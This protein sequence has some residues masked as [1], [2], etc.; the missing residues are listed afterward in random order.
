MKKQMKTVLI[1]AACLLLTAC[2]G[3]KKDISVDVQK[4]ADDLNAQT[5]SSD[6]DT[7]SQ[8]ATDMLPAIYYLDAETVESAAAYMSGGATA[9]EIAVIES[10]EEAGTKTVEE[11]LKKRVSS[12]S[13]LYASYNADEVS[14][15]KEAVIKSAGRY[16]VLV[17]CDDT[18]KANE[19]LKSCGF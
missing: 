4:L 17:V 15:L 7:L 8:T 18:K 5:I 14:R 1:L 3:K 6:T 9:C 16:T 10:K 13:D 12:Q 2:S 11:K 19:I